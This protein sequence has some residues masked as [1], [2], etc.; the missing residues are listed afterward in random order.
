[1]ADCTSTQESF[2]VNAVVY[3]NKTMILWG[4]KDKIMAKAAI[5]EENSF[6]SEKKITRQTVELPICLWL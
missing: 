2:L 1:M 6:N 3:E 4:E 5:L